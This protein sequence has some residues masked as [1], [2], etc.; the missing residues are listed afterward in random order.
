MANHA[1]A[2]REVRE[3]KNWE[4]AADFARIRVYLG[5]E[6]IKKKSNYVQNNVPKKA[7]NY[8]INVKSS[9]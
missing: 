8:I 6:A 3:G 7:G 2:C 4:K 1:K 9:I 5:Q